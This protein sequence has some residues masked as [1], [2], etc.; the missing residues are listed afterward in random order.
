MTVD[1]LN[2]R[3]KL[4]D[5]VD[6]YRKDLDKNL[7]AQQLSEAQKK[8][9]TLTTSSEVRTAFDLAQEPA[10]LRDRY[11]RHTFGQSLLLARRLAQSGITFVQANMGGLNHWDY[12]DKENVYLQRDMPAFDQAFSALIEDLQNRRMLDDTLVI[13]MSEMGRNPVLG[14]PVTGSIDNGARADGRNHWQWCWTG[15]FAGGGVRA[16]RHRPERRVGG[17]PEQQSLLP[18]DLGATIFSAL[19]IP[20]DSE[21]RDIQGRPTAICRGTVM[22]ELF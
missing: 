1:R 20:T 5:H 16:E 3:R 7:D 17:F 6:A 8:A 22:G 15:V 9:F 13:C 18:L 19:G 2:N 11:G 10:A 14:K 12:H 4:L 21:V